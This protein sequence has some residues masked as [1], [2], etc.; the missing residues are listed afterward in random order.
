MQP[1]GPPPSAD[2]PP[3]SGNEPAPAGNESDPP[4]F[5]PMAAAFRPATADVDNN[6]TMSVVSVVLCWPLAIP[7]V[8]HALR[9]NQLLQ[10]GDEEGAR[11]AAA[12]SRRWSRLALLVGLVGWTVGLLCCVGL[13]TIVINR[14]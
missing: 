2:E 14:T 8:L 9:V 11:A 7:A 1:D 5:E 3:P 6:M 12:Q 10:Q 4:S 13:V